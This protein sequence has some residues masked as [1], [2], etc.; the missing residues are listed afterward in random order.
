M[1]DTDATLRQLATK[2][3]EARM[4]LVT[5]LALYGVVNAGLVVIWWATG[6]RYPWFVWP[7]LGWGIG[8]VGHLLSYFFGPGSRT[9]QRLVEREM[10]RL[11]GRPH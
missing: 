11:Q 5:H 4:G 6:S 3:V 10:H 9:E 7:M 8:I 1:D 2:R